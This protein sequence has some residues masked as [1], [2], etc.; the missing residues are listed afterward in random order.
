MKIINTSLGQ[1]SAFH[2]MKG[3]RASLSSYPSGFLD[4]KNNPDSLSHT[5]FK[6]YNSFNNSPTFTALRTDRIPQMFQNTGKLLAAGWNGF[7]GTSTVKISNLSRFIDKTDDYIGK[8]FIK[9]RVEK[10]ESLLG[11]E[12]AAKFLKIQGD[13]IELTETSMAQKLLNGFLDIPRILLD[14]P[15]ALLRGAKKIPFAGNLKIW[16]TLSNLPPLKNRADE[17]AAMDIFYRLKGMAEFSRSPGKMKGKIFGVPAGAAVPN[18]VTKDERALNRLGTGAV[19]TIFVGNDFYNLAM[20]E[21]NDPKE[22]NKAANKRMRREASRI[23]MSAVMT[24]SVLSALSSY[25]NK[26]KNLACFAIAGSALFTEVFSRVVMGTPLLPLTPK[27][28]KRLNKK[29]ADKKAKAELKAPSKNPNDIKNSQ[30]TAPVVNTA[31]AVVQNTTDPVF[32]KFAY[33]PHTNMTF[34]A[35]TPAKNANDTANNKTGETQEKASDI[36]KDKWA[37][38]N[39]PFGLKHL[40][41]VAASLAAIGLAYSYAR[42]KSKKF[43]SFIK[44]SGNF[45]HNLREYV[46]K[47]DM[48]VK[49]KDL[50]GFFDGFEGLQMEHLKK[51]YSSIMDV[52]FTKEEAELL[53][54]KARRGVIS[55]G[56]DNPIYA[57]SFL[58]TALNNDPLIAPVHKRAPQVLGHIPDSRTDRVEYYDLACAHRLEFADLETP[59]YFNPKR[60][61]S[62]ILEKL[63]EMPDDGETP[64]MP[65]LEDVRKYKSNFK[66]KNIKFKLELDKPDCVRDGVPVYK[67]K[68]AVYNFGKIEDTKLKIVIDALEQP[69]KYIKLVGSLPLKGVR[70]LAGISMPKQEKPQKAA[71]RVVVPDIGEFYRDCFPMYKKYKKGKITQEEFSKYIESVNL[72]PFSAET[73]TRYSPT[74]LASMSRNFVT[75]ISS[76]FFINDFRNEVLLQSDG[77]NKAKA[78]EVT[79]ERSA[80]KASNFVLNKFFMEVFNN[81]FNKQYLSSLFGATAVAM[82]TELTNESSVRASIGVPLDRKHSREEIDEFEKKHI[83]QTGIKGAYYRFMAR[84]TGKKMLSEKAADKK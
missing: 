44:F 39:K 65:K 75:L 62:D 54:S 8:D 12:K 34:K 22:A 59:E 82:A 32:S 84:L 77:E 42:N 64:K 17:K 11:K 23:A 48:V 63:A 67:M 7:F 57:K 28:A 15:N 1:N 56:K 16:D 30:G 50:A 55:I 24:Y 80:H 36:A 74:A 41:G 29:R 26:S 21:K 47:K 20:Y 49:E 68:N 81:A 18:Y 35:A 69:F 6:T 51:A 72:K 38:K 45:L 31:S 25:V 60:K 14:V 58:R 71:K 53:M 33:Q 4:S 10:F 70:K 73:T 78:A 61:L 27:R 83:E 40:A 79:K 2:N 52:E 5:A 13:A 19:S 76:Y 9:T 66:F 3:D 46:S 43:D 37:N